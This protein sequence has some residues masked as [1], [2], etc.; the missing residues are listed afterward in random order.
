MLINLGW[1][2]TSDS[3]DYIQTLG[4]NFMEKSIS[5]RSTEITFS[6][7]SPFFIYLLFEESL[8]LTT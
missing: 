7:S 5:I 3:E 2:G 1:I 4:V 8:Q 6:V